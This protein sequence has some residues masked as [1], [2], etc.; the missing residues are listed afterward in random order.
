M[1]AKTKSVTVYRLSKEKNVM[2]I[3]QSKRQFDQCYVV[4]FIEQ[5]YFT[6]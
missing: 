2:Q 1:S 3:I 5:D 6:R 4:S